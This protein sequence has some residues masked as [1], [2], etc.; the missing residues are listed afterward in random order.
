MA[1]SRARMVEALEERGI[2]QNKAEIQLL[3][4]DLIDLMTET[5]IDN[6]PLKISGFG[7]F[8]VLNKGARRGRNP[9]TSEDLI[10]SRRKVVSFKASNKLIAAMELAPNSVSPSLLQDR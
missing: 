3:V 6:E 2:S 9:H 4:N 7:N 1:F 5:L 8:I 10:I